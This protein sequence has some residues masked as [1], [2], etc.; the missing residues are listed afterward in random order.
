VIRQRLV[1]PQ[2]EVSEMSRT[3]LL[4]LD[5]Q[6]ALCERGE[7]LRMPPLADE[8]ERR[9]VL[10]TAEKTLAAARD[11]GLYVVHV[12]LAF[13]PSYELRTN[14]TS[15]FAGYPRE[16]AMLRDSPGAAIVGSLA[17]LPA[18]PVLDKG[19][20]GAFGGTPLLRM[21]LA[22]GVGHVALGGVAANLV[23]ESTARHAAD[24]GLEVTVIEDM[25]ASFDPELHRVAVEKILPMFAAVRPAAEFI[26]EL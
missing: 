11:A 19:G 4:M 15:R 17:P 13:D 24:S 16:R 5:Y 26:A 1:I 18:E 7:H 8:V 2:R 10:A 3:A 23:V 14:R 25:C 22:N 9:G 21:L 12:R 20:V 6:V